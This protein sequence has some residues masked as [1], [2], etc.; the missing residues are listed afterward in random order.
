MRFT[1]DAAHAPCTVNSFV[2]LARQGYFDDT[3]C[4]RLTTSSRPP[5]RLLQCGDPTGS[6]RGGPGYT[7]PDEITGHEK[8]AVGTLAMANES[9]ANTGGSQFFIVYGRTHL[10]A[11]YTVFG[12]ADAGTVREIARAAKAGVIPQVGTADTDGTPRTRITI[13]SAR[14][15]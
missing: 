5:F 2:S 6:G 10:K 11:Q 1:L 8:Y 14:L 7:I 9:R 3:P 4:P 15:S 13:R 12:K